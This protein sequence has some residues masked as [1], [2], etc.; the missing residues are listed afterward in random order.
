MFQ[1]AC[2]RFA[3]LL[4]VGC[5]ARQ[6][7]SNSRNDSFVRGNSIR[8]ISRCL[9]VVDNSHKFWARMFRRWKRI[10]HRRERYSFRRSLAWILL[11]RGS[12]NE[13]ERDEKYR[14]QNR[15][16]IH[17]RC[18]NRDGISQVRIIKKKK[19][20]KFLRLVIHPFPSSGKG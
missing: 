1:A 12:R 4:S 6:I 20:S 13:R 14:G 3:S 5:S 16:R 10:L 19:L 11:V 17:P 2:F 15:G 8:P 18:H 7:A 9:F